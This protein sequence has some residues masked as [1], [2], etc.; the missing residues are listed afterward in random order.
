MK[1][2]VAAIAAAKGRTYEP[3]S[4][5]IERVI[6]ADKA[7][8]KLRLQ[9]AIDQEIKRLEEKDLDISR[10]LIAKAKALTEIWSEINGVLQSIQRNI[11]TARA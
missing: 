8:A 3:G 2:E 9:Q 5:D 4:K 7:K 1:P 11:V 6:L 10:E